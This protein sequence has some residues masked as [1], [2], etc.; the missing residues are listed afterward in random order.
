L[1]HIWSTLVLETTK[2]LFIRYMARVFTLVWSFVAW[3]CWMD[4]AYQVFVN[5]TQ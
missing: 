1:V 2:L 3:M 4:V 5:L